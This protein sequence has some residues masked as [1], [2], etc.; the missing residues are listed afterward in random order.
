[1]HPRSYPRGQFRVSVGSLDVGLDGVGLT[2]PVTT[3]LRYGVDHMMAFRPRDDF[4]LFARAALVQQFA[5]FVAQKT[6]P[7]YDECF[8]Y[9]RLG[10]G[11]D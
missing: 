11:G 1:M 7:D 6:H 5:Q 8:H 10:P 2:L 9:R 4:V 3:T